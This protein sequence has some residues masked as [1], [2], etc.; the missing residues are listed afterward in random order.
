MEIE[1]RLRLESIGRS[2]SLIQ[3]M[4]AFAAELMTKTQTLIQCSAIQIECHL[5]DQK[6]RAREFFGIGPRSDF[7]STKRI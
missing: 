5:L 3:A 6:R 2:A 7:L 1:M 4:L